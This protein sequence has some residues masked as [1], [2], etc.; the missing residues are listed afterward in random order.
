[1]VR[2]C[3]LDMC[4]HMVLE[5]E[6]FPCFRTFPVFSFQADFRLILLCVDYGSRIHRRSSSRPCSVD[7]MGPATSARG[8][9]CFAA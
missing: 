8:R 2:S 3:N 7:V 9:D 5:A 4:K 6:G 1:M